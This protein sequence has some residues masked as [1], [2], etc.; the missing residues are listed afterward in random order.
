[1]IKA[2]DL[3]ESSV[4]KVE[5]V[6]ASNDIIYTTVKSIGKVYKLKAI[7]N[8]SPKKLLYELFYKIENVPKWNPTLLELRVIKVRFLSLI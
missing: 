7:V 1:V 2:Y 6:T 5:K 8:Y 3:L 4:W